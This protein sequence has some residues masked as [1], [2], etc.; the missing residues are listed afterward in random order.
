MHSIIQQ[1]YW[2]EMS[3]TLRLFFEPYNRRKAKIKLYLG[4]FIMKA[5]LILGVVDTFIALVV[6]PLLGMKY[7][8]WDSEMT[9]EI[10]RNARRLFIEHDP[11]SLLYFGGALTNIL[12]WAL[13]LIAICGIM[14]YEKITK[15]KTFI[16]QFLDNYWS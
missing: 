11:K 2:T 4:G 3:G 1:E 9:R 15:K 10:R 5:Y 16:R 13:K 14:A 8:F 6:N 12:T 7:E